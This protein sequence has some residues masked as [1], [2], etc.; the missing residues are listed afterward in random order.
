MIT[1]DEAVGVAYASLARAV[2][3]PTL[4]VFLVGTAAYSG[5]AYLALTGFLS[6]WVAVPALAVAAYALFTPMH[7][8]VHG[9]VGAS[10]ILNLVIGNLSSLFLGPTACFRAYYYLHH[11]HHRHTNDRERDPDYWSGVGPAWFLPVSWLTTDFYYYVFYM[12]HSRE[13]PW[14]EKLE[15]YLVSVASVGAFVIL[16]A[17]GYA[18]EAVLY[19]FLPGRI[20]S[21]ALSAGFNFLPH[22][23][24]DAT[25]A[26]DAYRATSIVDGPAWLLT[27]LLMYHNYHLIHHLYP[28]VP[29]YRYPTLWRRQR[30]ALLASGAR[31]IPAAAKTVGIAR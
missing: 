24:Y 19:W 14:S 7:E 10:P 18:P 4:L 3:W 6:P 12:K 27:P 13:R 21:M 22:R 5:F 15:I 28:G 29:F 11:Q 31:V 8:A 25:A 9:S 2:Q 30:T 23:P 26:E 20:A 16:C 17:G 1:S